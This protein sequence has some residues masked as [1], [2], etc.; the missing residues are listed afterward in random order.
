MMGVISAMTVISFD[1]I[2]FNTIYGRYTYG[3]EEFPGIS[4]WFDFIVSHYNHTNGR[5]LDKLMPVYVMLPDWMMGLC[6]MAVTLLTFIYGGLIAFGRALFH[7]NRGCI[8]LCS[9]FILLLPWYNTGMMQGCMFINYQ[10]TLAL[11]L[12]FAYYFIHPPRQT[13]ISYFLLAMLAFT[14]GSSHESFAFLILP[15][16]MVIQCFRPSAKPTTWVMTVF[17]ILGCCFILRSPG[18][19][20]RVH[21]EFGTQDIFYKAIV[22]KGWYDLLLLVVVAVQAI[23]QFY[24]KR[25]VYYSPQVWQFLLLT[26]SQI[27]GMFVLNLFI[28]QCHVRAWWF[29]DGFALVSWC[30]VLQRCTFSRILKSVCLTAVAIFTLLHLSISVYW[31]QIVKERF[32]GLICQYMQSPD[33][34]VYYEGSPAV[35]ISPLCLWKVQSNPFDTYSM[36][37]LNVIHP[38]WKNFKMMDSSI[39]ADEDMGTNPQRQ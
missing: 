21:N 31:Q 4:K 39:K 15:G 20:N 35:E 16:L 27:I 12:M 6:Q 33:G 25:R 37:Y 5:S 23:R 8:L 17:F 13:V 3:L 7:N 1:D 38:T 22:R 32:D 36:G 34:V 9:A 30:F 26:C 29:A 19:W 28:N 10:L 14:A 11:A 24:Y 2:I 18:F